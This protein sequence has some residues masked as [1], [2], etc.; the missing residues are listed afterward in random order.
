MCFQYHQ[1]RAIKEE[2]DFWGV[3][4]EGKKIRKSPKH[5]GNPISH[6]KFQHSSL[7][8]VFKIRGNYFNFFFLWGGGFKVPPRWGG[9]P[10]FKNSRSLIQNGGPNPHRKFQH[11]SSIRKCSEIGGIEMREEKI[12]PRSKF[13][14]FQSAIKTSIIDILTRRFLQNVRMCLLKR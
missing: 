8:T 7:I 3:R 2:L 10:D 1:N 14:D 4:G 5:N 13:G 6:R 12:Y 9:G 11:S